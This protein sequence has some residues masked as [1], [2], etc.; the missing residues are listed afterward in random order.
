MLPHSSSAIFPVFTSSLLQN[1]SKLSV[2]VTALLPLLMVLVM[3]VLSVHFL[4]TVI[5]TARHQHHKQSCHH[6]RRHKPGPSSSSSFTITITS[7]LVVQLLLAVLPLAALAAF[8]LHPPSFALHAPAAAHRCSF[9]QRGHLYSVVCPSM[10]QQWPSRSPH[11]RHS[12]M[13]S[14]PPSSPGHHQA[15]TA[16]YAAMSV[17]DVA[18]AGDGGGGA[19]SRRTHALPR[20]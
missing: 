13:L 16:V 20:G 5:W 6:R 17:D 4:T 2:L 18:V 19:A 15:S 12:F 10:S 7:S 8:E 1:F 11:L 3:L 9:Q 14:R